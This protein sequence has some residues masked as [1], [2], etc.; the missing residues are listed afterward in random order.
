[1]IAIERTFTPKIV[2]LAPSRDPATVPHIAIIMPSYAPLGEPAPHK[3]IG[4][5]VNRMYAVFVLIAVLCLVTSSLLVVTKLLSHKEPLPLVSTEASI[6]LVETIP[7]GIDLRSTA[8]PSVEAFTRLIDGAQHSIDISAFYMTFSAEGSLSHAHGHAVYGALLE[9]LARGVAVRVV[10]DTALGENADVPG[11]VAAGATVREISYGDVVGIGVLHTK[12]L[13]ADV[14][15]EQPRA[16]LGSANCD[17]RSLQHVQE[18][19]VLIEGEELVRD[20]YLIFETYWTLTKGRM[21]THSELK[22]FSS[23]MTLTR[24]GNVT[25][26]GSKTKTFFSASPPSLVPAARTD[27]ATALIH[28][29]NSAK[30]SLSLSVMDYSPVYRGRNTTW[31]GV[32]D[33]I[34]GAAQR[35]VRVRLLVGKWPVTQPSGSSP[36]PSVVPYLF[37]LNM[38]KNVEVHAMSLPDVTDPWEPYVRVNHAKYVVAD[39]GQS[40]FVSTSNFT[41]SYW[42]E[43]AGIS[44]VMEGASAVSAGLDAIF[45]RNWGSQFSKTLEECPDW[46]Q[47]ME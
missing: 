6:K 16:Y 40:I 5:D 35:G 23:P 26:S 39:G 33:A 31:W 3:T 21:P 9:A 17:A 29:I 28:V 19:G 43:S 44:L 32:E 47:F 10:V 34:R 41:P 8:L 38:L 36:N 7:D 22:R 27:D 13:L 37:S 45:E 46:V 2:N 1:M 11:L 4:N 12:L 15:G 14:H 20:L 24:P 18:L 25:V 42:H 30:H